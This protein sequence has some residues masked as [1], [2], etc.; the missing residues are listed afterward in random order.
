MKRK[1]NREQKPEIKPNMPLL[2]REER[3][4]GVNHAI[5]GSMLDSK[6]NLSERIFSILEYH[7]HPSLFKPETIPAQYREDITAISIADLIVNRFTGD[8]VGLP[9]P[10]QEYFDLIRL[11]PPLDNLL[12]ENLKKRLSIAREFILSIRDG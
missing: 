4:Y 7:R 8:N 11:H 12:T 9:V 10:Q 6:W 3:Y 1:G 5:V 2:R